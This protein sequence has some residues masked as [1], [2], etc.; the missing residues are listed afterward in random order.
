MAQGI[1]TPFTRDVGQVVDWAK[2]KALRAGELVGGGSVIDAA[3]QGQP[4]VNAAWYYGNANPEMLKQPVDDAMSLMP[5][6]Q[7]KGIGQAPVVTPAAPVVAPV[8]PTKP[9]FQPTVIDLSAARG[10]AL[11][12]AK[13]EEAVAPITPNGIYFNENR[14]NREQEEL[15][16][17][18]N[19]VMKSR[20]ET[21]TVRKVGGGTI[22]GMVNTGRGRDVLHA[23]IAAKY[24]LLPERMKQDVEFKKAQLVGQQ[25]NDWRQANLEQRRIESEGKLEENKLKR[26]GLEKIAQGET[27]RKTLEAH[28]KNKSVWGEVPGGGHNEEMA[29]WRGA[30]LSGSENMPGLDKEKAKR[31]Y[32][33]FDNDMKK[34]NTDL[35]AKGKP[36]LTDSE[37]DSYATAYQKKKGWIQ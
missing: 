19:D 15:T 33:Q 36:E 14:A 5:Q 31:V 26:L 10:A 16:N 22:T 1:G 25:N 7:P 24:G 32:R 12:G 17:L 29:L 23:A 13:Q 30:H 3:G 21:Q 6:P 35:K 8:A 34:I 18:I 28:E 27:E 11:G 4:A 9:S 20:G 2:A 37:I